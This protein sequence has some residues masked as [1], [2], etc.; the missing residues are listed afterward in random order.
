MNDYDHEPRRR[1]H[2]PDDR[3]SRRNRPEPPSGGGPLSYAVFLAL[4]MLLGGLVLWAFTGFAK[5]RGEKPSLDPTAQPREVTP[6]A[7]PDADEQEAV[8]LFERVKDSVVNVDVVMIRQG[9]WGEQ[10]ERTTS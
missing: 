9:D 8:T 3:A 5:F 7:P 2:D 6:A 1:E 4:G 10:T